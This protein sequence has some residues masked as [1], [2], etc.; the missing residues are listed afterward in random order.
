MKVN[1][2]HDCI[3]SNYQRQG[4]DEAMSTVISQAGHKYNDH[5]GTVFV[6]YITTLS[7]THTT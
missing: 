1:M 5:L 2:L 4:E 6:Y 7:V 3:A